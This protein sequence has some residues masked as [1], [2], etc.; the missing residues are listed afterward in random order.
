MTLTRFLTTYVYNPILMSQ[1]RRRMRQGK[2]M[3]RR[4]SFSLGPFLMLLVA[5]TLVTMLL[6]GLWH[7][8]GWQF[9]VWGL[10][11]GLMLAINHGWR[12]FRHA[13]GI[14]P[15]I[16]KP[17]RPLGTALTFLSVVLAL[18]FFR[19]ASVSEALTMFAGLGDVS[20]LSAFSL[21][22][23]LRNFDVFLV[24]LGLGIIFLLPNALQWIG[25][26][27]AP[28]IDASAAVRDW[29]PS[30]LRTR[31]PVRIAA[32]K[33]ADWKWRPSLWHGAAIGVLVC[34][35]MIRVFSVAPTQFLY[36]TF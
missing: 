10:C 21:G 4:S 28:K 19:S 23:T 34:F 30:G 11:H 33:P 13:Y 18:V 1:T 5:P 24:L 22:G 9:L 6:S 16:G 35:T 3:L 17:F 25:G 27:E 31:L 20:G 26:F 15:E 7:G 14:G 12:A 2:P 29:L 32:W 36:F 8:A